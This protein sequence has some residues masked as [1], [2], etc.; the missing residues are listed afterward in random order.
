MKG[1]ALPALL[2]AGVC[3]ISL[4]MTQAVPPGSTATVALDAPPAAAAPALRLPAV[5]GGS[6]ARAQLQ[7]QVV[8]LDVW[9]TWC[10]PCLTELPALDAIQ[11]DYAGRGVTVLGVALDSG[12]E[13]AVAGVLRDHFPVA[14]PMAL[15]DNAFER[16]WGGFWALPTTILV[17]RRWRVRKRW[18]GAVAGKEQQLRAAIEQLL[19]EDAPRR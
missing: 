18:R 10:G 2:A 1:N 4:A 8:V 3:V 12:D 14:Y 9:A 16:A 7:G 17:D 5:G 11:R 13:E 15:G 19:Q 6:V